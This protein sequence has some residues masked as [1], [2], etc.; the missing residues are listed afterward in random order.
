M[1]GKE[2]EVNDARSKSS[3]FKPD[4]AIRDLPIIRLERLFVCCRA[5]AS[6]YRSASEIRRDCPQ[7]TRISSSV[8]KYG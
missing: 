3:L 4:A 2:T 5:A 7:H 1:L 6:R 8:E